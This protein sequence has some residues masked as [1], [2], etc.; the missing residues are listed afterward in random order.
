MFALFSACHYNCFHVNA[1]MAPA[2]PS[3]LASTVQTL[4]PR[5]HLSAGKAG[6]QMGQLEKRACE[7]IAQTRWESVAGWEMV[8]IPFSSFRPLFQTQLCWDVSTVLPP[9]NL[10]AGGEGILGSL[11]SLLHLLAKQKCAGHGCHSPPSAA[12]LLGLVLKPASCLMLCTVPGTMEWLGRLYCQS[13]SC[14]IGSVTLLLI[15]L[16]C[17]FQRHS[18]V[19]E[20]PALCLN[21]A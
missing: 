10:W 6:L 14:R 20:V 4:G 21:R 11:I 8:S 1:S 13:R 15:A 17:K 19:A 5:A 12:F 7:C 3:F 16:G 9:D 18:E 2:F